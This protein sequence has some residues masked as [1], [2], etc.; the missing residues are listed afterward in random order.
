MNKHLENVLTFAVLGFMGVRL[1]TGL[2][3]SR[4]AEGRTLVRDVVTGIRWR[5]VW[6]VPFVLAAI[7]AVA[8]AVMQ[9]PGLS[10]GWWSAL[11]GQGNPV[12]GSNDATTGT[13][14]AWL[15]PVGFVALLLP[16]LP[17]F[18]YAE[19]RLF[20]AG[21]ERWSASRR[22]LKILQFGLVHALIGIP[23]GAALT[24]SLGGAYFM[25][26]YLR[27]FGHTQSREAATLESTR[28]HTA[29]NAIIVVVV[30]VVVLLDAALH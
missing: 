9:V 22:T 29:Y 10:W 18:A 3:R 13:V 5:H 15:I 20:R 7:V 2:R 12:F 19:E 4:T 25:R 21:A 8:T 1:V 14:W 30:V 26:V 24:L 27:T 17:L 28:A 16:A 11:G 6:P 23:I